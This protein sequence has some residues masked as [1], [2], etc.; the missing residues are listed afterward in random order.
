[1]EEEKQAPQNGDPD[2][3]RKKRKRGE[4]SGTELPQGRVPF[5]KRRM[6]SF[7]EMI[8]YISNRI[9][10][11]PERR[12]PR[13]KLKDKYLSLLTMKN[14]VYL[15][16]REH[17]VATQALVILLRFGSLSSDAHPW[18]RATD[19]FKRTGIKLNTQHYIIAR[20]RKRGFVIDKVK[21]KGV[22]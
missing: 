3:R 9:Q 22:S 21:R 16:R 12:K 10:H 5:T 20:W 7:Q 11:W 4:M 8:T 17:S 6:T 19:V 18:L 14:R 1:M 15:L 13:S 2:R